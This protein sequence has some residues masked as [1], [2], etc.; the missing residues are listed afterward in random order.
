MTRQPN[1]EMHAHFLASPEYLAIGI[2]WTVLGLS[3]ARRSD[4]TLEIVVFLQSRI[5]PE[6]ESS[7]RSVFESAGLTPSQDYVANWGR[8]RILACPVSADA[9]ALAGL[10]KRVL[11]EGF[12]MRSDDTLQ[13]SLGKH[14][15]ST[16]PE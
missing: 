2:W 8:V 5:W 9:E 4:D 16:P 14:G 11:V 6:H 15:E 10:C 1:D 13:Y 12:S 7:A 3:V